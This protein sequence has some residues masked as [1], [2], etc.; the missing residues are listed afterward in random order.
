[1]TPDARKNGDTQAIFCICA[2]ESTV[3]AAG[4]A[5]LRVPGAVFAGEFHDYITAERRPQFSPLLKT[6]GSVV[7][8]I[9]FDRDPELALKTTERLHQT[10]LKKVSTVG[11]VRQLDAGLLLRAM[12]VGCSEFLTKPADVEEIAKALGRFRAAMAVDPQMQSGLGRVI[13][14]F[15][16]KG[17]VGTSVLAVHLATHLA[18]THGKK[19]LL[20]DHKRELGHIALYLGLKDTQ[21]HF[22]ELL[23]NADRLDAE[24]LNGFILHH[25]SGLDVIASPQISAGTHR[26]KPEEFENTMDFLRR[27]YDYILID[28]SIA[29][30]DAKTSI[31]EQADEVYLISTPDVASLRDLARL[32]EVLGLTEVAQ[33]KLRVVV[34][35]STATDSIT[36][37]E[38][39]RTVRF[40][41][42]IAIPNNY[43]ELLRAINDGEP[44]PPEKRSEFNQQLAKWAN[45]I[46]HGPNGAPESAS[47]KH[48]FAF[49][50]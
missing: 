18:R 33:S 10:F 43:F 25:A 41:I 19:T 23:R 21:Y 47:K 26:A 38:I 3:T 8:L 24:L 7:A 46:V 15:G 6:A 12:R 42:S 27:Q 20:V 2:D 28:S 29:Y 39:E 32:I 30:Q 37:Q 16:A 17:G 1:M 31:L 5:A 14:F 9:D 36:P 11:V 13:A 48:G 4:V 45:E 44:V 22:D 49:W 40:P 50:R 34:N 35:R